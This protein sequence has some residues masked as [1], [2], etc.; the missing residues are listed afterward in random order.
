MIK[1]LQRVGWWRVDPASGETIGVMDSG[2]HMSKIEYQLTLLVMTVAPFLARPGNLERAD[3]AR[4]L[5]SE[6][7][8]HLMADLALLDR[9]G[10]LSR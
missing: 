7:A 2:F 3:R 5:V 4:R 8:R 1:D 10:N 6:N 9:P